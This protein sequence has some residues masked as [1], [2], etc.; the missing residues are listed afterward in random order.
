MPAQDLGSHQLLMLSLAGEVF[1]LDARPCA[2]FWTRCTSPRCRAAGVA[3][4]S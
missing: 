2:K 3:R 4:I 1:A